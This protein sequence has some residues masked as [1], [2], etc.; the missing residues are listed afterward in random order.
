[1]LFFTLSLHLNFY[2]APRNNKYKLV[3]LPRCIALQASNII[4]AL[5]NSNREKYTNHSNL[6]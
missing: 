3:T 6:S 4:Q 2:F 1:M 5:R